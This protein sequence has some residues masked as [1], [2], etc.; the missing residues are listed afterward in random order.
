MPEESLWGNPH[1]IWPDG[2]PWPPPLADPEPIAER[3]RELLAEADLNKKLL[4]GFL[5][6]VDFA[7]SY[8]VTSI[9]DARIEKKTPFRILMENLQQLRK[10]PIEFDYSRKTHTLDKEVAQ[11]FYKLMAHLVATELDRALNQT[12]GIFRVLEQFEIIYQD[13]IRKKGKLTFDDSQHLL[14]ECATLYLDYRLDGKLD[15]WL[16]DEFQDTSDQQWKV[17]RNLVDEAIQD[18]EGEKSFFYVGDVK[19]A[20]YGWRGGNARLFGDILEHYQE[21]IEQ[22]PLNTS[23]RS[24]PPIIDTV[25]RVFGQ[26]PAPE[27][28]AEVRARWSDIW[29]KHET[30]GANLNLSGHVAI[31]EPKSREGE[32]P[33]EADRFELVANLL[34]EID[35]IQRG[36]SVGVLVR[37]NARGHRLVDILRRH[38]LLVYHEGHATIIDNPVVS[39]LLSLVRFAAHPGDNLA[40]RHLQMTPFEQVFKKRKASR[41][42]LALDLLTRLEKDGIQGLIRYWGRLLQKTV[43]LDAFGL[44]RLQDLLDAAAAFDATGSRDINEFLAFMDEFQVQELAAESAVRVMTI[45]QSKGL[46]FDL[47][48]LP[49]LQDVRYKGMLGGGPVGLTVVHRGED[50]QGGAGWALKMPRRVISEA[51]P[52]LARRVREFDMESC[53]DQLCVVYVAMTRA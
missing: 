33:D 49:D 25:N 53:F 4:A 15:H 32:K 36:I 22:V 41:N 51:D 44:R 1:A 20:I 43:E 34:K 17:F 52:V 28:Y 9:W 21:L 16:F 14:A 30:A 6:V 18:S 38:G 48:I 47:V 3:L 26:L 24:C 29:Q 40:W 2:S 8:S 46:G 12:R 45:H 13:W 5:E 35:P 27:F 42:F 11:L 37:T 10:G 39:A 31:L 23:Y 7:G 50:E 19:Q